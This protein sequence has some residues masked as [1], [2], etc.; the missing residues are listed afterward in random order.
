MFGGDELRQLLKQLEKT[1]RPETYG[2]E[3]LDR[4]AK[5]LQIQ[6]AGGTCPHCNSAAGHFSVCPLI[7]RAVAEARAVLNEPS[8]ADIIAARGFGIDLTKG[9]DRS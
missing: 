5:A 7:N 8:E 9:D 3:Y 1:M 4:Y 2:A 6:N